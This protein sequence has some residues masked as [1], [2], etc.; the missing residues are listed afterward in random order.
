[1]YL[2]AASTVAGQTNGITFSF[3]ALGTMAMRITAHT[4]I[5]PKKAR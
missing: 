4:V 1:M 2:V 3:M 5:P